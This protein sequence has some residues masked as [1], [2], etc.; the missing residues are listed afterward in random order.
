M[1]VAPRREM[2]A[3]LESLGTAA[4]DHTGGHFLQHLCAVHDLLLARGASARV[5]AA[6]MFHSIY[7][8]ETFQGFTLPLDQRPRVRE[9]I[10]ERAEQLAWCNCVMD[11]A[12]FDASL[13]DALAGA[14]QLEI[15]DR[16]GSPISL[17][18]D[19]LRELAEVHLFD[20]LE[21][22][23]RVACDAPSADHADQPM[24]WDYRRR[25]YGQMAELVG[26]RGLWLYGAVFSREPVA[27]QD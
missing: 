12:S 22:V 13:G 14:E 15:R 19:K 6:G 27:P 20:W 17:S 11:R 25:A 9:L 1:E 2:V 3:F 4:V 7:G 10:G 21:Q 24:G 26:R 8:T 5:A 16:H 23:E 18:L